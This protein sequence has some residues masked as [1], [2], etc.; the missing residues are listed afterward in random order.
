MLP[1]PVPIF[2]ILDRFA[3]VDP[4]SGNFRDPTEYIDGPY[5]Y[6][7]I[8]N[9]YGSCK[10]YR[11]RTLLPNEIIRCISYDE[12]VSKYGDLLVI[13]A[14]IEARWRALG[15]HLPITYLNYL[16]NI[17][18]CI[19]ELIGRSRENGQMTIGTSNINKI[20]KEPKSLFYHR[21][22]LQ[23]LDLIKVQYVT[24]VLNSRGVKSLMLRLKKYHQPKI[25]TIPKQG[26]LYNIVEYLK[27]KPDYSE[28]TEVLIKKGLLTSAQIKKMKKGA[29]IFNIEDREVIDSK[30]QRVMKRKYIQIVPQSDE[31]SDSEDENNVEP[32]KCQYKVGVTI[33]RQAY[34]LL[35]AAGRKG[36]TQVD[37][38]KM[39]GVEVYTSR[40]ICGVF[41]AKHV[42][43]V[44]L[45]DKGRQRTARYIAIAN[46]EKIDDTYATEKKKFLEYLQESTSRCD[47]DQSDSTEVAMAG[48]IQDK[49]NTSVTN[50]P[51]NPI[52]EV[53]VFCDLDQTKIKPLYTE[54][55]PT[56][57]QLRFANGVLK[58][59][60]ERL[61][62]CGYISLST[63]V[64]SEIGETP[65][66]AKCFKIFLQK[67]ANNGHIKM[68]RV[69]WPGFQNRY[70]NFICASH[71]KATDDIIKSKYKEISVRAAWNAKGKLVK[72]NDIG[73]AS[74]PINLTPYPRYMKLQKL[75][76][77]I[78]KLV[79]FE[80]IKSESHNY[81]QGFTTLVDIIPEMTVQF[82]ICLLKNLSDVGKMK[83]DESLFNVKLRDAPNDLYTMILQ[84]TNLTTT[85]R[86]AVKMLAMFGL[87]QLIYQSAVLSID[88][89]NT[90][91]FLFY[92]NRNAKI[93]DTTG[94]WPRLIANPS[95]NVKSYRFK[96]FDDVKDYWATV[97]NIS[98]N[99]K[100]K[101]VDRKRKKF[102]PPIRKFD[103]VA[104]HDNGERYG[105]GLGACGFDSFFY[106]EIPRL[107][108]SVYVKAAKSGPQKQIIIPKN[109]RAA[110]PKKKR[111]KRATELQKGAKKKIQ[112]ARTRKRLVE[113]PASWTKEEDRIIILSKVAITIMSPISQPGCL[114]V[115]NV[116]AKDILSIKDPMKNQGAVHRRAIALETNATWQHEKE[117]LLN[118][119]SRR[120]FVQKYEGQLKKIRLRNS[121]NMTR[122]L[123]EARL[124]MLE[125][126]WILYQIVQSSSFTQKQPCIALDIEDFYNKFT[127]TPSTGNKQFHLYKAPEQA[128]LKEGIIL[129]LFLSFNQEP[130][131]EISKKVFNVL[132]KYP[133]MTLRAALDQLRKS[134]A[135][136][137]KEKIF[138]NYLY[139]INFEDSVKA[140][141][142]ISASYQRKWADR[143]NSDF[144]DDLAAI[145]D[146]ELPENSFKGS[147]ELNCFLLEMQAANVLE[148]ISSTIPVIVD[149]AG[150]SI[151]LDEHI[152]VLE[153]ETKYQ[154]KSGTLTLK[155]KTQ[156]KKMSKYMN[157]FECFDAAL[158]ELSRQATIPSKTK[159]TYP[160][161]EGK[162]LKYIVSKGESGA[163][164][165][166]LEKINGD[167]K[168]LIQQLADLESANIIKRIGYNENILISI[169][170]IES[171]TIKIDDKYIIPTPWLNTDATIKQDIF[172]KWAG[173]LV[174][175]ICE[176]P[177]ATIQYLSDQCEY[178]SCRAVQDVCV[179][180]SKM[181][182]VALSCVKTIEPDL[183]SDDDVYTESTEYNCYESFNN[184]IVYPIKNCTCRYA[185]VRKLMVSSYSKRSN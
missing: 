56:L 95:V 61:C 182:C 39:L 45:E 183:F 67:L 169:N 147:S 180:L 3:L 8:E 24:Q 151:I 156:F 135:V 72:S 181:K 111:K 171:L 73:N 136:S 145:V 35:L 28:R 112:L 76:E 90:T 19:L 74:R 93:I 27:S 48:D 138:N 22:Q 51:D 53:K 137:A 40:I 7:P 133:E 1:E 65:L 23:D 118:E 11:E 58:V 116:V 177:G 12:V 81:P 117:C 41:K 150:T 33:L 87:V 5:E 175:K 121:G 92:V 126:M 115:R 170:F 103:E 71:V 179:F 157:D 17:H 168:A 34:E 98:I 88:H 149:V 140:S 152:S 109:V 20:V 110:K 75:H 30:K 77:F 163:T 114:T 91:T 143:L 141:Y 102:T 89:N 37:I 129:S 25:L 104:E 96:T 139:R 164:F 144:I 127:I 46:T 64:A 124:V 54:S 178:L 108:L 52:T 100:I 153:V 50:D 97:Q 85:V 82:A 60:K 62:V 159:Q 125:L 122:F 142:K 120:R 130:N 161:A 158:K 184:I 29:N 174:S 66:D 44:F 162:V 80:P 128:A 68:Y 106:T 36:L 16:S 69:K 42:V 134:G 86:T 4:D 79:Y 14:N 31:S 185:Y 132:K 15:P 21:K 148:I 113:G 155:N 43:R 105:D 107:W 57:R 146:S 123:H 13:V 47:N 172:L 83:I 167:T 101:L 18:Y 70:T 38:S 10:Y 99:T 166:E 84:S 78:I 165:Y 6:N 49:T 154:L 59:I 94:V 32:I 160:C 173:V 176:Y 119:M 9:E 26:G 131:I 63:L 55:Y 2:P